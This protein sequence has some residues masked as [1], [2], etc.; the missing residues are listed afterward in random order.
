MSS[1]S[2]RQAAD[3]ISNAQALLITAGAGMGVDSGLPDF[4]GTEGFWKAYPPYAKLGLSFADLA[5]PEWLESDPE[6]AWGFYGHRLNLYR[7]TVPH[8]GFGILLNWTKSKPRGG[9][10]FTSNVDGAFQAAQF[11]PETVSEVHGS[12]LWMQCIKKCGI[13]IFSSDKIRPVI[14]ETTMRARQPL[15]KC[16]ACGALARPNILMFG[17]QN[18]DNRRSHSS[19]AKMNEWL[20]TLKPN[21]LVIVELGA[22][23]AIPTIR[24]F[25]EQMAHMCDGK[26]IRINVRDLETPKPH[27]AIPMSALAALQAIDAEIK[28]APRSKTAAHA[29]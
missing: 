28:D 13:G 3:I 12:L 22:G 26:L 27:L 11:P 14:D 2:I 23:V 25:S 20:Q 4:R 24:V 21:Q 18:W 29:S 1:E 5:N 6:F 9:Y 15:P 10:V 7:A 17:D 19:A 8:D 16:P